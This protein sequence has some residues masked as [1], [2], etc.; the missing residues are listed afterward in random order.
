[1]GVRRHGP[2]RRLQHRA[3]RS[4]RPGVS[5]PAGAAD[6]RGAPHAAGEQRADYLPRR[7]PGS[8]TRHAP[9]W[10]PARGRQLDRAAG[11][12][13]GALAPRRLLGSLTRRLRGSGIPAVLARGGFTGGV[14]WLTRNQ[15]I[16]RARYGGRER[17]SRLTVAA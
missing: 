4:P 5:P 14:E 3:L 13:C 11:G 1:M 2:P 12:P 15:I 8:R 17:R 6:R 7:P 16:E 9:R 10:L